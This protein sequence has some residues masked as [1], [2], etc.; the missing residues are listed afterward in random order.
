MKPGDRKSVGQEPAR[1]EVRNPQ[2]S[3][4]PPPGQE[5]GKPAE[6]PPVPR[7]IPRPKR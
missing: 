7:K 6:K 5:A 1:E 3:N 2:G 4:P